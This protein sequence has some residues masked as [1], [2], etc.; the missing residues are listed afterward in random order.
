MSDWSAPPPPNQPPPVAR[1]TN[2][3]HNP[4][5]P[6]SARLGAETRTPDDAER[7]RREHLSHESSI[8]SIGTLYRIGAILSALGTLVVLIVGVVSLFQPGEGGVV[9]AMLLVGALYGL[10]TWLQFYLGNGLR[11]LDPKVRT[12]VTILAVLGLLGFPL[13]TLISVYILYLLH[14]EKGKRIMTPEYRAI[15]ASTPHIQYKTPLWMI[16]VVV[17][18]VAVIALALFA[19]MV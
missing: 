12:L 8:R 4:Y 7:I 6:P 5:A 1:P 16:L 3:T 11:E 13:G 10:L 19:A 15:V 18:L 14:S 17:A 2:P 9:L